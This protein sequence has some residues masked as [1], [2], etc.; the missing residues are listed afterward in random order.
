MEKV[1]LYQ[2]ERLDVI[3]A[4]RLQT[5][6]YEYA[7]SALGGILGLNSGLLLFNGDKSEWWFETVLT[8]NVT[9]T[10]PIYINTVDLGGAG[11]VST[12]H[13][14]DDI[15]FY[16]VD[17][18][19]I[20][21][22]N[23]TP[24]VNDIIPA[25]GRVIR[26]SSENGVNVQLVVSKRVSNSEPFIL[27]ARPKEVDISEDRK[28]WDSETQAETTS[29]TVTQ[30]QEQV[31]FAIGPSSSNADPEGNAYGLSRWAAIAKVDFFT[32]N[33][34]TVQPL[35]CWDTQ[36]NKGF[37]T[38]YNLSGDEYAEAQAALNILPLWGTGEASSHAGIIGIVEE[39]RKKVCELQHSSWETQKHITWAGDITTTLKSGVFTIAEG[40]TTGDVVFETPLPT[41]YVDIE[42]G[43]TYNSDVTMQDASKGNWVAGG[44]YSA[45][46]IVDFAVGETFKSVSFSSNLPP[47]A[48]YFVELSFVQLNPA[49]G[50]YV[51]TS[52]ASKGAVLNL[53]QSSMNKTSSGFSIT[54]AKAPT[55]GTAK[56]KYYVRPF[57]ETHSKTTKGFSV[58][59]GFPVATGQGTT[60]FD[61]EVTTDEGYGVNELGDSATT[62]E[63]RLDQIGS[64]PE[65]IQSHL[66]KGRVRSIRLHTKLVRYPPLSSNTSPASDWQIGVPSIA[67]E[68]EDAPNWY[69][70]GPRQ[71]HNLPPYGLFEGN[72]LY[73]PSM[74][75]NTHARSELVFTPN[76]RLL[77]QYGQKIFVQ[78]DASEA[79][80]LPSTTVW[81]APTQ[82][83][84]GDYYL[85]FHFV[86]KNGASGIS[87]A[88]V[89]K[90]G[91]TMN[92]SQASTS[93]AATVKW[94]SVESL[95]D[96]ANNLEVIGETLDFFNVDNSTEQAFIIDPSG[97]TQIAAGHTGT[98]EEH[99]TLVVPLPV[100]TGE[101]LQ[102]VQLSALTL[103]NNNYPDET[104]PAFSFHSQQ[105][106]VYFA[107][108]TDSSTLVTATSAVG[109]AASHG[110]VMTYQGSKTPYTD[111]GNIV[112]GDPTALPK[113]YTA[114]GLDFT[115]PVITTEKVTDISTTAQ[116]AAIG[117]TCEMVM[118]ICF[119]T[120]N[121]SNSWTQRAQALLWDAKVVVDLP[122]LTP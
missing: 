12:M 8:G 57:V 50:Q 33:T 26:H 99:C 110:P 11:T 18:S 102:S 42:I 88:S 91:F 93:A 63:Y 68:D 111:P 80:T 121:T 98:S 97:C 53:S 118:L 47:D 84:K 44:A 15:T 29:A 59:M 73:T 95:K 36:F 116:R 37:G 32:A 83:S 120:Q 77:I 85:D 108:V 62:S 106:H 17:R 94:K 24:S 31:V 56:V 4:E 40:K 122:G 30:K 46:Q 38:G 112:F 10:N 86:S 35:Y 64:I 43:T 76:E 28:Y 69:G 96:P 82:M 107:T 113:N 109:Q 20:G 13:I 74:Y 34:P 48:S 60:A 39:L 27:Y 72:Q 78:G 22:S 7:I 66:F 49:T 104:P 117:S 101:T 75:G 23:S 16:Y 81:P 2:D 114:T 105:F 25:H 100:K 61:W 119:R 6:V 71:G 54:L 5:K 45:F 3:D 19:K 90:D 67:G 51:Y 79:I 87:A 41:D 115:M 1:T 70:T 21:T 58:T 92:L 103:R 65:D 14:T 9:P 55:T 52:T 89:T